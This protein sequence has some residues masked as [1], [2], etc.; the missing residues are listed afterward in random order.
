MMRPNL[1]AIREIGF[2]KVTIGKRTYKVLDWHDK[3]KD[4]IT[5]MREHDRHVMAIDHPL[6]LHWET[7]VKYER[8]TTKG[9]GENSSQ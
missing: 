2:Q 6:K 8:E 1:A 3:K 7:Y 5:V 4:K 9:A